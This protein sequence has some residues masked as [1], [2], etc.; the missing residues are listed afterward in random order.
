MILDRADFRTELDERDDESE[1]VD[2]D[3]DT[4]ADTDTDA[5]ADADA[6][7]EAKASI[8]GAVDVDDVVDMAEES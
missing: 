5:D 7:T 4:E 1:H 3:V 6:E 8:L 2:V